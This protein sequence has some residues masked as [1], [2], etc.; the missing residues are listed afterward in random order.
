MPVILPT[1]TWS[2]WL[3]SGTPSDDLQALLA[4]LPAT[5]MEAHP[6]SRRVNSPAHNDPQLL[7]RVEAA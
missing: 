2:T 3:D 5:Q 1:A 7:D 6:V 4:P